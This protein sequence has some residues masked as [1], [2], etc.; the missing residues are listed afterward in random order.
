MV[1]SRVIY[2]K[3]RAYIIICATPFL[4]I[5]RQNT[6][7]DS[8]VF[9]VKDYLCGDTISNYLKRYLAMGRFI[10]PFTDFGFHRIFGQ[11]IHKELLIDFLNQL[12]KGEREVRDIRIKNPLQ[13]P[14]LEE[15]RGVV[16]DVYCE[17][18]DGVW[19]VVEMQAAAQPYFYDRGLYYLARA[20]DQQG[21]RGK[22][23][24]FEL[25]PVYGVFFLNFKMEGEFSKFRTDVI[26]ADRSTGRMF[27]DKIRQVYLELPYFPRGSW[28]ECENDF[29]RWIYLLKHME[30]LERMPERLRKSVFERLLEVA[31]VASLT[32]EERVLYDEALKRYRD[33][34][35]TVEYAEEKGISATATTRTPSSTP[36]RR[37]S[38]KVSSKA[39]RSGKPKAWRK[40]SSKASWRWLLP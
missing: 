6:S 30:T 1:R 3:V 39:L 7:H 22:D 35:N 40:A 34:K 4:L 10:N 29:E 24:K 33:Y 20:I 14:E 36:R 16:F 38:R 32:K 23:W 17:D 28:E 15:G 19:F 27:S 8:C 12:L 5:S 31:D 9:S 11:E 13:T 26:L 21:Q 37:V 2:N 18:S 25:Q